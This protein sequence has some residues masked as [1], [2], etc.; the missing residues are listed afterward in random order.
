MAA[1]GTMTAHSGSLV[2]G[3]RRVVLG[4]CLGRGTLAT[5]YRATLESQ[6]GVRRLV[7]CKVFGALSSDDYDVV[8][9]RLGDIVRS[10]A[11]I[12]HP[13]VAEVL[14]LSAGTKLRQP[15][16]LT[17]LVE[18]A[19]LRRVLDTLATR[20]RRV[21]LD[22]ALFIGCEIAEGL[23]GAR[24]AKDPEGRP[25]G[26]AHLDLSAREVLL[27]WQGGVKLTD[28]RMSS[29]KPAGS[30]VRS[31]SGVARRADTMAPEVA[32]GDGGD[33]RSDVFSLGVL[34]HEL[35]IG[36]R[37]A[38]G[39]TEAEALRHARDG[40]MPPLTFE[41]HLPADV[42]KIVDRAL[43]PSPDRRYAHTGALAYE[44]RRVA[45]QLGVGDSRF[46]LRSLLETE[47]ADERSDATVP[48]VHK[49]KRI[50]RR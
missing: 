43:E 4:T 18:G 33:A 37:F 2:L 45:F 47:L 16:V 38:K 17:E 50:T 22:L 42:K 26:I 21:P 34:L 46:F 39:I 41:P 28:F 25:L 13:N 6:L 19:S 5:V 8:V 24:V 10:T 23:N 48:S 36:P 27:S 12:R 40:F 3:D 35:L 49:R 31:L 20:G 29:A 11:C 30:A 15:F 32:R 9:E 7:A 44:L 1:P 14:E